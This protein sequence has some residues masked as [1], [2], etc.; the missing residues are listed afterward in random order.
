[1]AYTIVANVMD[2]VTNS[3]EP[4]DVIAIGDS[5]G[6]NGFV[7]DIFTQR[8]GLRS[9]NLCLIG[10]MGVSA[11]R[12]C[13]ERYLDHHPK[14]K[15]ILL[16][17]SPTA[18]G[19][20]VPH[21]GAYASLR[22]QFFSCFEPG[23]PS[24]WRREAM[25]AVRALLP[26]WGPYRGG[27]SRSPAA[28]VGVRAAIPRL[29]DKR[30]EAPQQMPDES[31]EV[32]ARQ[33]DRSQSPPSQSA[34]S[35]PRRPLLTLDT[36]T[37]HELRR[38]MCAA[39]GIPVAVVFTPVASPVENLRQLRADLSKMGLVTTFA[40]EHVY[41]PAMFL[42]IFQ[43]LNFRGA[44]R[45]TESLADSFGAGLDPRGLQVARTK[46]NLAALRQSPE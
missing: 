13:L 39:Q 40:G 45:F 36:Q 21:D 10:P 22:D 16:C 23:H 5:T 44:A 42:D 30:G 24:D 46:G 18:G 4:E 2:Y 29:A 25:C 1:M 14:P 37:R 38:L 28:I 31:R 7:P 3:T 33:T 43:H 17:V 27:G 9:H 12:V 26:T 32:R 20:S 6:L 19:L 11:Y 35:V 41:E 34:S 15:T 8:T